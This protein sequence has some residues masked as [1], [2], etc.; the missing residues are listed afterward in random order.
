MMNSRK[1]LFKISKREWIEVLKALYEIGHRSDEFCYDNEKGVHKKYLC[2][3][4]ISN[5]LVTNEEY[6]EFI[7]C[8]RLRGCATMA[9][10]S[11]GLG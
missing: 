4:Q 3:F 6:I 8:W 2:D 7:K 11:L 1:I 5:K 10:R 9:R